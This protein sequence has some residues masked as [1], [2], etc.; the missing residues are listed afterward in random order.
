[1]AAI[2]RILIC[3]VVAIIVLFLCSGLWVL[4]G[5]ESMGFLHIL[6]AAIGYL[7]GKYLNDYLKK[8]YSS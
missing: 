2:V 6:G 3:C 8:K 5:L 1:M 4:L 7:T